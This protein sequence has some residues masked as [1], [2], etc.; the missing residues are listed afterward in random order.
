MFGK[1]GDF[2]SDNIGGIVGGGLIGGPT[3]ALIGGGIDFA[4][5][6][7]ITDFIAGPGAQDPVPDFI[8]AAGRDAYT[9]G[10]EQILRNPIEQFGQ[11]VV[12]DFSADSL[13]AFDEIRRIAGQA[14]QFYGLDRLQKNAAGQASPFVADPSK[15]AGGGHLASVAGGSFLGANPY[16]QAAMD[17]SF[18]PALRAYQTGTAPQIDND[19]ARLGRYGSGAHANAVNQGQDMFARA[20][21]EASAKTAFDMYNAERAS[22]DNAAARLFGA[23]TDAF[24]NDRAREQSAAAQMLVAS[25][26]LA[27]MQYAPANALASIG[28]A[29]EKL[30]A[31]QL[32]DEREQFDQAQ[33]EPIERIGGFSRAIAGVPTFEN[34]VQPDPFQGMLGGALGYGMQGFALGGPLGGLIGGI[35]GGLL[36]AR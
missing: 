29:Q 3:G 30:Q 36:G 22:Q 15:V 26:Q 1:I 25:P 33:R 31:A 20:L 6:G 19:A 28:A 18:R 2:V 14:P 27:A 7:G 16:F 34:A 9:M 21:A 17:A 23:A 8:R 12:P 11:S 5:G 4:T 24:A 35:G 10:R 32:L 13:A